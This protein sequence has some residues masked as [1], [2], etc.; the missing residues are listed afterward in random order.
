MISIEGYAKLMSRPDQTAIAKAVLS[1]VQHDI[2]PKTIVD[3]ILS[4]ISVFIHS[5]AKNKEGIY[6]NN[7]EAARLVVRNAIDKT[8][9]I[10]ELITKKNTSNSL[11]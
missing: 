6:A 7:Y 11:M 8:P 4:I 1:N 10:E 3:K 5:N 9:A 2:L